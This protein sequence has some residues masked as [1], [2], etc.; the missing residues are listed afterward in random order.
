MGKTLIKGRLLI[1]GK[2]GAPIDKGAILIEDARIVR[3]EKAS[4]RFRRW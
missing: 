3:V 2:G 1:D 4:T